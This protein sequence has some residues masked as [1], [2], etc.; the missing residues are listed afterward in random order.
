[1]KFDPMAKFSLEQAVYTM[2]DKYY[3]GY[4]G[5]SWS[6]SRNSV[7]SP[8]VSGKVNL[9][10]PD[11]YS[12]VNVSAKA[13]GYG[14]SLMAASRLGNIAVRKGYNASADFWFRY[15]DYVR[16]EALNNLPK[17]EVSAFLSFID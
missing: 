7:W 15:V 10:N 2:A 14:L 17:S 4:N 3:V 13:A 8:K 1:M 5:G 12:D 16:D 11:N 9:V 6:F